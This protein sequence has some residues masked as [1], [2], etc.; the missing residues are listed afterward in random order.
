MTASELGSHPAEEPKRGF[1]YRVL[2]I[3]SISSLNN[4]AFGYDVGVVSG[5]LTD[6]AC[7]LR[8]ST[9]EQEVATSGLNFVSGLGALLVSGNL[10]DILGRRMTLF[11]S[12]ALLFVGSVVVAAAPNFPVLVLGRAL[13][14]LGSGCSWCACGVYITEIAP[15]A[16]RGALVSISDISINVGILLGYAFDRV[17][18][19]TIENADTR[20]RVK[21][22]LSRTRP[23]GFS[24]SGGMSMVN[25][26]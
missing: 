12:A 4:V 17:I 13:Q 9:F 26:V 19:V 15:P 3:A 6:M 18:N 7:S 22:A 10:L 21:L 5:S 25:G 23:D 11:I 1:P 20:W 2:L 16:Y 8:L 14:G 24:G